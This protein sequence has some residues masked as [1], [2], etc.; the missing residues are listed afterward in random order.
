MSRWRALLVSFDMYAADDD[1]KPEHFY[2]RAIDRLGDGFFVINRQRCFVEVN[3]AL[4]A[5]YRMPREDFL[6]RTP[7]D[8]V[9]DESRTQLIAQMAKIESTESRR[10][11]LTALRADGSTFP[12]LFNNTTFRDRD[13]QIGG[14][15][16]FITDI[17]DI[18]AAQQAVVESE[19]ELRRI[20]DSMQETYYRTDM[21][22]RLVRFSRSGEALLGYTEAEAMG[23]MLADFYVDPDERARFIENMVRQGGKVVGG[24]S[25]LRRKDGSDIWVLTNAHFLKDAEG[26]IVGI[27]G[28]SRDNTERRRNE[29]AQR[30]AA[31]VFDESGEGILITDADNRIISVN[32]SFTRITGYSLADVAGRNPKMLSSGRQDQTFYAEVWESLATVGNWQGELWNRRKD[33][34]IYPQWIGI[35]VVRDAAGALTHYV[36]IFSDI[37]ERK[38]AQAHIEYL[39]NYDALTGLPN[40]VLLHDRI[41]QALAHAERSHRPLAVLF[42]DLDRFKIVNDSLGHTAGDALLREVAR[43]L[44]SVV[45]ES[46]TVSRTGG[47]EF[48]VVL[49]DIVDAEAAARVAEKVLLALDQPVRIE[50]QD[51][52]ASCS[53]GISMYPNDGKNFEDLVKHA[54]LAM[55]HAKTAGR[56]A[57]CFHNESMTAEVREQLDLQGRLRRAIEGRQFVLHYQPLVHLASG[58]I[59][60]A[61]ALLRWNDPERGMIPPAQF[62]PA[63]ES[64]GLIVPLGDWVLRRACRDVAAWRAGGAKDLFV[65]VNLS[66]MQFRRG[67]IVDTVARAIAE[68]DI[69]PDALELEITESVML[70]GADSVMRTLSRLKA[71]GVRLAIDDFGTGYSSLAYLKR[72]DVDKVKIDQSFVRDLETDA[73]DAAIVRAIV[74]MARSLNLDVLAEGVETQAIADG[75]HE[76]SCELAQGWHFGRPMPDEAFRQRINVASS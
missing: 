46:D 31:R 53:I 28:T 56:N 23:R 6:G 47:D 14:S 41:E 17:S 57:Y 9:T 4:C 24:E 22:G 51:I 36:A 10:Y 71:L 40:R 43:R 26:R 5:L 74:Q 18:V 20:V 64:G 63:A 52:H 76:L 11:Q 13:G 67:D 65:A 1:W 60:G 21:D 61:E 48:L 8:F 72:L 38:E 54:D 27:E 16:G 25:H 19:R 30:L 59:I 44:Q 12:I 62:I 2:H 7:L 35:S 37:T 32:R 39:A 73:D 49:T 66:V 34:Q 50:G 68:A 33:G 29:Q 55:Y 15:F 42:V 45:R 3:D 58:R 70:D 69:D 75:L